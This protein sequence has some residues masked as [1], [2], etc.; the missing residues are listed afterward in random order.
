VEEGQGSEWEKVKGCKR[1]L[2]STQTPPLA[3]VDVG[4]ERANKTISAF[5]LIMSV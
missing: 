1:R 3:L 4:I 5:L 2:S